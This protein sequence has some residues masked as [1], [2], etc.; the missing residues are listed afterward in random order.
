MR[1]HSFIMDLFLALLVILVVGSALMGVSI[2][3]Y[4]ERMVENEM[5]RLNNAYLNQIG[6]GISMMIWECD[7][8]G[9]K[10]AS[11]NRLI[12]L[13]EHSGKEGNYDTKDFTKTAENVIDTYIWTNTRYNP[14][15]NVYVAGINGVSYSGSY[16]NQYQGKELLSNPMYEEFLR[17]DQDVMIE[18]TSVNEEEE[19]IYR[20]TFQL[21]R[22]IKDY[23]T[24]Q[25]CGFVLLDISEKNLFDG[26]KDIL[27]EEKNFYLTD[28]E[29]I[30]VS[31]K[32]K[33][34]IGEFCGVR[35]G[36]LPLDLEAHPKILVDLGG[37]R[38][39]FLYSRIQGTS[40]Y[41]VETIPVRLALSPLQKIQAFIML[42]TVAMMI[43]I[44]LTLRKFAQIILKPVMDIREKMELVTGGNLDVTVDYRKNNEFG[45]IA[46]SFNQMTDQLSASM[47]AV[48]E[49]EKKKRLVEQDFLRAQ[50]NPHFIYNTLSSIRFFVALGRTQEAE[51]MLIYFSKILRKTLSRSDEFISIGEE[52]NTIKDYAELQMLRYP[53]SFEVVYEIPESIACYKIP[54]FILQ[55]IVENSIFYG[56]DQDRI[57][58]I[59]IAGREENNRIILTVTDNGAG[60]DERQV[61]Q[62]FDKEI[63]MNKVGLTNV[64][65]RIQVNYGSEYGLKVESTYGSGTKVTFILPTGRGMKDAQDLNC[66]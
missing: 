1:R 29:G 21:I 45:E 59:G 12:T 23:I 61:E 52:L 48:I 5:L 3:F 39:Y 11:D 64:H 56:L 47:E 31:E 8:L 62:I 49:E 4:S 13:L 14:L 38:S 17:S 22:K 54:A 16:S 57:C 37:I 32:N 65:E 19:G 7:T 34:R 58:H 24:G 10:I 28:G 18:G 33:Q 44:F 35:V 40:W 63:H 15:F 6:E 9:E 43:L 26:Y 41:L 60:M 25:T 42:V 2:Y 50:I 55:P 30:I 20:Y 53:D 51:E 46:E 27:S 36:E 66:R